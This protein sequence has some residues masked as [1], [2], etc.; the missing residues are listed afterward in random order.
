MYGDKL[1]LS[2]F[3]DLIGRV[4]GELIDNLDWHDKI[5]N[6]LLGRDRIRSGRSST[7]RCIDN[8]DGFENL[9]GFHHEGEEI[10]QAGEQRIL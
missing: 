4:H 9:H 6:F 7:F 2:S 1:L 10:L 3:Y 8:L 5:D